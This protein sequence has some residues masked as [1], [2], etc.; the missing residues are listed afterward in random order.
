MILCELNSGNWEAFFGTPTAPVTRSTAVVVIGQKPDCSSFLLL[1]A[2]TDP[3]L[4]ARDGIPAG[5]DFTYCQ[6]WGLSI[7]PG[8]I[9][10][11]WAD[12]RAKA[13]PPATDYLD[14]IVK[15]D[16]AQQQRYIDACLAVKSKYPNSG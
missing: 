11:V 1:T 7:T 5:Y 6:Q 3:L 15:G 9:S 14:A 8:V 16:T 13:Y 10:R 2:A 12:L 4:T